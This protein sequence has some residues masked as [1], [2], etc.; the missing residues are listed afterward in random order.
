VQTAS[1]L[2]AV[3]FPTLSVIGVAIVDCVEKAFQRFYRALL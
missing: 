1:G 2:V 3:F